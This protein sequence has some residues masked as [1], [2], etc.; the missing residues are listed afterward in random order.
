MRYRTILLN[1]VLLLFGVSL[2]AQDETLVG[3]KYWSEGPL[4]KEDFSSRIIGDKSSKNTGKIEY[5]IEY[6]SEM[7]KLGNLKF[8]HLRTYLYMDKLN[9]WIDPT[10]YDDWSL[11]YYQAL[12]DRAEVSRRELQNALD[13]PIKKEESNKSIID[14]YDRLIRSRSSAFATESDNGA[15]SSVIADYEKQNKELLSSVNER[16]LME[17]HFSKKPMGFGFYFGYQA[18]AFMGG[19][20]SEALPVMHGLNLG[21]DFPYKRVYF[22]IDM[23]LGFGGKLKLDEFYYDPKYDYYWQK[24]TNCQ[25]GNISFLVGYNV[26][27][28]NTSSLSP[29]AGVGVTFLDQFTGEK[30]KGNEKIQSEIDG[31]RIEAGLQYSCK[32]SRRLYALYG[33]GGSYMESNLRFKLFGAMTDNKA[34]GNFYSLNFGIVWNGLT[35]SVR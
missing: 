24:G 20:V 23:T 32:L 29:F 11:R 17:P 3:I 25:S 2:S 21:F 33:N 14:Y 12:F 16:P 27:D 1:V 10:R 6:H 35:W 7:V 8:A 19:K 31:L 26:W 4:V 28:T 30:G 18:E 15:I 9:S 13:S 34:F 5:S 22:G